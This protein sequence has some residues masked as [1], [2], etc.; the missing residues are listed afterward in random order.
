M[1]ELFSETAIIESWLRVE[2]ALACVQA[3]L[4]I[5]PAEAAAAICQEAT[6]GKV[7]VGRLW[8][9]THTVGYPIL[10]LI[11]Q[12]ASGAPDLVGNY[13][14][15]GATTQDIVDTGLALQL[16]TAIQRVDDLLV[17]LG[18]CVQRLADAHKGTVM[19]ARTHAQQAVPTTFGAK[20]AVWLEELS[21][22]RARLR[23]ARKRSVVVQLFGAAGTAAA[24]G[25][26][27]AEVRRALAT[28]LE[29]GAVDIPWHTARDG[30][31]E[32]GFVLG[33]IAS[34]C[35]KVAREVID[36]SR[37]EI[38]EV[39]EQPTALSGPSS[40]MPQKVNPVLS[41]S[42]VAMSV[43]ARERLPSLLAAM[44]G[45]HERSA[46]E[47]QIEWEAL[48]SL[49][50]LAAACLKEV[51]V[52][53]ETLR[54]LPDHMRANLDRDGGMVMAEAVMMALAPKVGRLRAHHLVGDACRLARERQIRLHEALAETIHSE[55]LAAL[56]SLDELTSPEAYLGEAAEIVDRATAGW[57]IARTSAGDVEG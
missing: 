15:W 47:W 49:F 45:G 36:L 52:V 20:L 46:G 28:R 57:R 35:G 12:I 26:G 10:P 40:T 23:A 42:V 1:D 54:V 4:G 27:S 34:T 50:A 39:R 17:G 11:R 29:L 56:A 22:H 7:D 38:D 9:E 30:V 37:T 48:P 41:E 53:L 18:D 5:V 3:E 24:L 33:A 43:L 51:R 32:V 16:K 31:A 19:P 8:E 13:F 55:T 2:R 6:T 25:A 14:H 21:R 44:Q